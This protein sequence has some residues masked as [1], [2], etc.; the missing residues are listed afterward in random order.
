MIEELY[1]EENVQYRSALTKQREE[2]YRQWKQRLV[3]QM[4]GQEGDA[5]NKMPR[6][7]TFSSPMTFGKAP[8][9]G[10]DIHQI[11]TD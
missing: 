4:G 2:Q 3:R 11:D 1:L 10:V 6:G 5:N 8:T 7:E 9:E